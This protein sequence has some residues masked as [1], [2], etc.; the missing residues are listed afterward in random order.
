MK[1]A[2]K[3]RQLI[4]AYSTSETAFF[5]ARLTTYKP[6]IIKAIIPTP[7]LTINPKGYVGSAGF[8]FFSALQ[9]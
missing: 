6:I 7:I 5:L 4:I 9:M 3:N 1:N 2:I 8:I